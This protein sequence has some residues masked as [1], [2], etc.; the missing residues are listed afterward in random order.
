MEQAIESAQV[1]A[2]GLLTQHH[3]PVAGDVPAM[4]QPVQFAGVTRGDIQPAP[5]LGAHT[6]EVLAELENLDAT[7]LERLCGKQEGAA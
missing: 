5:A 7:I 3:H 6:R 1:A 4:E 2:R